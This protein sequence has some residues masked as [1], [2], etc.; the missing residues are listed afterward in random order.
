MKSYTEWA[1]GNTTARANCRSTRA[2]HI[3]QIFTKH[4]WLHN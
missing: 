1:E 4:A 2:K 3:G